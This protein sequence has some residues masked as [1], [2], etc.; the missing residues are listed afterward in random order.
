M[1][2]IPYS[3]LDE[4]S[5]NKYASI[6]NRLEKAGL[7]KRDILDD[8]G[9]FIISDKQLK[10]NL[11]FKGK[12]SSFNGLKR[13]IK[14]TLNTGIDKVDKRKRKEGSVNILLTKAKKS[15]YIGK[16][17]SQIKFRLDKTAGVN[18][19]FDISQKVQTTFNISEKKA[20]V[21]TRDI[22]K[23]V[24]KGKQALNQKEKIILS[25]FS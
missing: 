23:R 1:P 25:Y 17:L 19:F 9:N 5:K 11:G 6:V 15:G 21:I 7:K 16:G 10:S 22:L 18:P 2:I 20:F 3:K 14:E 13:N 12:Q 4:K 8:K 24:K